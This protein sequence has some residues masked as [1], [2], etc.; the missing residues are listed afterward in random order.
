M[1]YLAGV[2][3]GIGLVAYAGG[4]IGMAT[5]LGAAVWGA[6]ELRRA[7]LP[8]WAGPPARLA[9]AIVALAAVLGAG[10]FAGAV[11]ALRPAPVWAAVVATGLTMTI[12]ARSGRLDRWAGPAGAALTTVRSGRS[13]PLPLDRLVATGI[14]GLV[15]VQ[16]LAKTEHAAAGGMVHVDSLWYHLPF[17]A[18]FVQTG[19]LSSLEGIG[20]EPSRWFPLDPSLVHALGILPFGR[21]WLSPF[22]NAAWL[23]LALL[24]AWCLGR[25][26]GAGH[27]SV[28]G[29]AVVAGLPAAAGTQPGQGLSDTA[30]VALLLAAV[31]LSVEGRGD[32]VGL[33]VAGVATGL[34]VSSKM[35]VAVGVAALAVTVAVAIV[36]GRAGAEDRPAAQ[37]SRRAVVRRRLV[38]LSWWVGGLTVTGAFWFAR[39]WIRLGN[40]MPWTAWSVGPFE[41]EAVIPSYGG[42]AILG[43]DAF[44][45]GTW[46]DT[47]RPGLRRG[48]GSIWPLAVVVPLAVAASALV[49]R[50]WPTVVCAV[51]VGAGA[52]GYFVTPETSGI[53]FVYNLRFLLPTLA[54]AAASLPLIVRP[55][56]SARLGLAGGLLVVAI[57]G[58]TAEHRERIPA[59]PSATPTVIAVVITGLAVTALVWRRRPPAWSRP[60]AAGVVG[61][62]VLGLTGVGYLAEERFADQRYVEHELKPS[63]TLAAWYRDV[64]DARIVVWGSVE[65]YPAFGLDLSNVVTLG[66]VPAPMRRG[67]D[68]CDR[69]LPLLGGLHDYAVLT[70]DGLY[71]Q[72]PPEWIF[73]Q[74]GRAR[75]VFRDGVHVVYRLDGPLTVCT[76]P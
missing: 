6:V 54:V 73:E 39:N 60:V 62:V 75:A 47:Y 76:P 64:H 57:V 8:A 56:R 53:S 20:P 2:A 34:A 74:S 69:W 9:E 72:R 59:W 27:L 25:R 48:F 44:D 19:N 32:R 70:E 40:P 58:A 67:Q 68:E 5:A 55:T 18:R 24:A 36:V 17:A 13:A 31:A 22:A 42:D 66:A 51:V 43:A 46:E 26:V 3:G 28:A 38:A 41:F 14:T 49:R 21:D 4:I 30:A 35:S 10:R 37:P 71:P 29:V 52:A 63:P 50:T 12:V 1:A 65:V 61:A 16:W 33:G 23:A 15:A 45:G 11:G 7:L